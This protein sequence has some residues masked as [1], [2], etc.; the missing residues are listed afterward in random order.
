MK[1][2]NVGG[3]IETFSQSRSKVLFILFRGQKIIIVF[4]I[5]KRLAI[6]RI[7][8]FYRHCSCLF[9]FRRSVCWH[10]NWFS[11][12]DAH[13]FQRTFFDIW[14]G[15]GTFFAKIYTFHIQVLRQTFD[16]FR[17]RWKWYEK[18]TSKSWD[19]RPHIIYTKTLKWFRNHRH[20]LTNPLMQ[21]CSCNPLFDEGSDSEPSS[22]T[23]PSLR[24]TNKW[25]VNAR[26]SATN[27][28]FKI[29]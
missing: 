29:Y 15:M 3:I 21:M 9:N 10:F 25:S 22:S 24:R 16:I 8:N 13:Y 14:V 11:R 4:C 28:C 2:N 20:H 27:N 7:F 17:K 23:N 19:P 12:S 26:F 18:P 5:G 6:K 1:H